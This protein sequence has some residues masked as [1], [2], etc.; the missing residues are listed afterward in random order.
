MRL[1]SSLRVGLLCTLLG[2]F[3]FGC[4]KQHTGVVLDNDYP[5][6]ATNELVVYHAFWQAVPFTTPVLPGSSSGPPD[7]VAA[8]A[9]TVLLAPG[10]EQAEFITRRVF[11][12]D[13][14]G[15]SYDASTCTTTGGRR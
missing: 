6:S 12:S 5:I 9:N 13:F 8:S 14:T 11:A 2:L 3:V 15:L 10:W 7:T 1:I 4:D